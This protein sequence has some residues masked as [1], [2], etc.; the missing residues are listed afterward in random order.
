M[1]EQRSFPIEVIV[2]CTQGSL[3]CEF[4]KLH[5]FIEFVCDG[6]VWTHQLPRV[7]ESVRAGVLKQHPAMIQPR[8]LPST[9][10]DRNSVLLA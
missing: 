1:I 7:S 3:L 8:S 6:P 2:S 10:G 5:E 9:L 4:S